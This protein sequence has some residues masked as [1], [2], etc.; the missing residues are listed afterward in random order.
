MREYSENGHRDIAL[1]AGGASFDNA[2][3]VGSCKLGS[4]RIRVE[5]APLSSLEIKGAYRAVASSWGT[6]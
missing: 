2:I 1:S 6:S 3:S 4:W 5:R